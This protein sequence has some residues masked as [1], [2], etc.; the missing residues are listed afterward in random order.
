MGGKILIETPNAIFVLKV[1]RAMKRGF[2]TV[3]RDHIA[4]CLK[5]KDILKLGQQMLYTSSKLR[6]Q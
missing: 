6:E 5:N 1:L 2:Y 3:D 4:T